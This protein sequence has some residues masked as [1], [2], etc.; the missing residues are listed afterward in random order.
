MATKDVVH[1]MFYDVKTFANEWTDLEDVRNLPMC[2]CEAAGK[3]LEENSDCVKIA[4]M[5]DSESGAVFGV[6]CIPRGCIYYRSD[7]CP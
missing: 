3:I 7:V 6:I 4:S 5:W 2:C 1:F